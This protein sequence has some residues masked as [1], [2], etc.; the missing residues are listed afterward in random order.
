MNTETV[1]LGSTC[2]SAGCLLGRGSDDMLV[3]DRGASFGGEYFNSYRDCRGRDLPVRAEAAERLR[4]EM[5][6]RADFYA[7][8]PLLY[9]ELR[10]TADRVWLNT[11]IV[12][13]ASGPEGFELEV[14]NPGGRDT[15]R[16]R[17]L[18]DTTTGGVALPGKPRFPFSAK[19]LN[20]AISLPEGAAPEFSGFRV[21]D[22]RTPRE[23]FLSLELAPDA[24]WPEARRQFVSRFAAEPRRDGARIALLAREF[25]CDPDY[26][27]LTLP[28]GILCLNPLRYENPLRALDAGFGWMGGDK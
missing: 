28:D 9:R 5:A 7:L 8:A 21:R 17:R 26:E 10:G 22:G 24:G 20:A 15:V 18:V 1:I 12:S 11:E 19:R 16:C 27:Q 14:Y 6:G 3:I 13:V 4:R 23:R 2:F 25:D